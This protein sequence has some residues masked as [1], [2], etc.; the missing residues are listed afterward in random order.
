MNKTAKASFI[1]GIIFLAI[2]L[3]FITLSFTFHGHEQIVRGFNYFY[4]LQINSS[5]T[6]SLRALQLLILGSALMVS[7]LLLF[8]LTTVLNL[9]DSRDIEKEF[10]TVK[11]PKRVEKQKAQDVNE[12]TTEANT[13][14]YQNNIDSAKSVDEGNKA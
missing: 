13:Q 7:G 12:D 5:P 4:S 11:T 14:H 6:Q 9:K 3:I 1:I 8:I 10:R 2:S